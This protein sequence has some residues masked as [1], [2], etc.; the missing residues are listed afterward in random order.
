M[1]TILLQPHYQHRLWG[2]ERLKQFGF[3]F[4]EHSIGE[5]WTASAL[6]KGGTSVASEP[7]FGL[8][9]R[10]LYQQHPELFQISADEFPLLIKWIDANDDLS[11]QVHPDD[12]LANRL[13]NEPYGKNECWYILD[14]PADAT[15]IYGHSYTTSK[16]F[17]K[18]LETGDLENGLIRKSIR[19]GDF[20]YVPAGT[21]HALTRGVCVLEIQQ[22][23]DT[24]YR[25]YDYNRLDLTTGCPRELHVEKGTTASFVPHL[26]YSEP[27]RQLDH[28]R[29]SLTK[30]SFFFVEKWNVAAK[31][32]ITTDTF[33]LLSV[34]Q[35]TLI[36]DDMEVHTGGTLLLPA[37]ESFLIEGEATCLVAGVPSD[38]KQTIRIGIDLGGTNTRIAAVSLKGDVLKQYT[39]KTQPQLPFEETLQSIEMAIHQFG[40]EFDIQHV[41]IVA[42]GPLDLKR[43]MF[44]T[45]P[46][47]PNCHNQ[48]II[49]PLNQ[50]LNL[51]VSLE[52]D[53]NAAA[54]A[55][56]KFGAG[57][58]YDSVFYVTVS[59]GIG[60]GYVY[61]HQIIRGAN[62][63]AGEIGNMIIRSN[64]PAHPV[65]NRGSLESLAS[66]TALIKRANDKGYTNVPS[67]LLD[68]EDRHHFVEELASGLANII[69]TVDPDVIVLGGGVMMSASLFW[70]ELQ[71]AVSNKMYPHASGKTRLCLT[72]LSGDAGVIGAAFVDA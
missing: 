65:L 7:Y 52:N 61:K 72:Q 16:D 40:V 49:E 62:G 55:E 1:S 34:V 15:L 56:A 60:G 44:L 21:I 18:A 30:N 67:L 41:G 13:E 29:T 48:K 68:A 4:N 36:I 39:F 47:L 23:S 28:F 64:G 26:E 69:H 14:A 19:P 53:A 51:S 46:N 37:N 25:L 31:E 42:P 17:N 2:G 20:F 38:E 5:A 70:N 57:K 32:R 54:L 22:S 8:S 24:T 45:P 11:V 10:E 58:G 71:Q 59:T 9:L 63:S 27:I 50:R 3:E 33:R 43:G 6:E 66:G 12:S 35:G